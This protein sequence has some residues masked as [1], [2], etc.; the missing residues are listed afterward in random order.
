[1]DEIPNNNILLFYQIKQLDSMLRIDEIPNNNIL[2]F[3]HIKQLDSMLS[4]ALWEIKENV[5]VWL[6][7][8]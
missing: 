3:Y 4:S 2:L 1:M 7:H 6:E 8:H 5:K